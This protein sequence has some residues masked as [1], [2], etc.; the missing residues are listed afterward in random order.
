MNIKQK[1]ALRR[2]ANALKNIS[3]EISIE[4][5][6]FVIDI[7]NDDEVETIKLPIENW[8]I[9][10]IELLKIAENDT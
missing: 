8:F 1:V 6:C 3:A 9:N 7:Y 2:L 5:S 10:D 4:D